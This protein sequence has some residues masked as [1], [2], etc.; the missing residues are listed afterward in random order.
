MFLL[1]SPKIWI[2]EMNQRGPQPCGC[3]MLSSPTKSMFKNA[4]SAHVEI[5]KSS[6]LVKNI[7]KYV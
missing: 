5:P 7:I 6:L 2:S 4:F 3:A 1:E